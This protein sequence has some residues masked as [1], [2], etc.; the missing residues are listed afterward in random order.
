LF[1]HGLGAA[2][3]KRDSEQ[4]GGQKEFEFIHTRLT[5]LCPKCSRS[6]K[7]FNFS[8][9]LLR[10]VPVVLHCGIGDS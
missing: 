7:Q 3:I 2:F 4:H 5:E 10:D 1:L 8:S 9:I 6:A